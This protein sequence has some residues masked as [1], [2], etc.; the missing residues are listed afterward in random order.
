MMYPKIV[1]SF[2]FSTNSVVKIQYWKVE[3][4]D[5]VKDEFENSLPH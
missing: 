3:N 1:K 2:D 5:N 4:W